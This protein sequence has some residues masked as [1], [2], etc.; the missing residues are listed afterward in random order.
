V[1]YVGRYDI[2]PT[3]VTLSDGTRAQEFTFTGA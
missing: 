2:E 3:T 1:Y